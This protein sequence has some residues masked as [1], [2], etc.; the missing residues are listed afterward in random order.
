[1]REGFQHYYE[2]HKSD[3]KESFKKYYESHKDEMK[4]SFLIPTM[5]NS[6]LG[7]INITLITCLKGKVIIKCITLNTNKQHS[8]LVHYIMIRTEKK[9]C[10]F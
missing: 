4:D 1:M 3:M 5:L 6:W 8:E 7:F 9:S 10:F 2:S